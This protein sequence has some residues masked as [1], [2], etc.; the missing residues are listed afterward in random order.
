MGLRAM[1]SSI[2]GLQSD[3]IWLDVIGNNIANSNTVGYKSSRL[4]FAD[5]LSQN[6]LGGQAGNQGQ[7]TGGVDPQQIGLGTRVGSIQTLFAQ[8]S[9]Q[10][11]GIST[12]ISIQGDGFLSARRGND[13]LL[14]RAGNLTF[15]GNGYLV[16]PNGDRIQGFNALT[17]YNKNTINSAFNGGFLQVTSA[18]PTLNTAGLSQ[19]QDIQIPRD[20][21]IPPK[22]T[23]EV[24]F[25]GNLDSLQQPNLLDLFP[26]LFTGASPGATLPVGL[27]IAFIGPANALDTTRMTVQINAS[28]G[29]TLQQAANLSTFIPGNFPP[30][31]PLENGYLSLTTVQGFGGNYAWEQSPPVPP[32]HQMSETVYDSEGNLRQITVQFYQVNDLGTN[33]INNPA[34]P[35]QVCYAWYAFDTTGGKPVSTAGLLGGTGIGEGD[36]QGAGPF[37]SYDRGLVNQG[38]FGDFLWF[39]TEGSL[40][41]SGGVGG[42]PGP[43]GLGVNYMSI[44]RVYLPPVN[45][46][47]PVS[48]IPTQGAEITPVSLDF[49]SF[50]LLGGTQQI[51]VGKRDGIYSDAEGGYQVVNGVN[52]YVPKNTVYAADQNGYPSGVLQGINIDQTGTI[53]GSFSN[54]RILPLA[55]L[56]LT[57]VANPEGLAKVGDNEFSLSQNSGAAHVGFGGQSGFGKVLSGSLEGSNVD[58]SVELSNMIIA[59]RGFETNARMIS[60][61]NHTLDT[62]SHLGQG[63]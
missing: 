25:K 24:T 18:V 58:L 43:P 23:T 19:T 5:Q 26:G 36:L 54:G 31:A 21:T 41:S 30:P 52:T 37:F 1:F 39:N 40:A 15:D 17:V 53:Q 35:N 44:P 32:A 59:Q 16:N 63:G 27:T 29:F 22:A 55:Q 9:T 38:F 61:V 51:P 62:L 12:D 2:S 20:M 48:P 6:I 3:S 14:T 34:G 33:G 60:V 11:T 56:A 28:G 47:P 10:M 57:Q 45:F 4:E 46:N 8:G 13:V 50:G 7:G 49:G 42:F